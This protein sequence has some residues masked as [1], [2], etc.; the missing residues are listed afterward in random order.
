MGAGR[1]QESSTDPVG[2]RASPRHTGEVMLHDSMSDH[3]LDR[4]PRAT[5]VLDRLGVIQTWNQ[6]ARELFGW[7]DSQVVGRPAAEVLAPPGHEHDLDLMLA[8]IAGGLEWEGDVTVMHREGVTLRV[9]LA[10]RPL[11][12]D[13]GEV[14]GGVSVWEDV[15]QTRLGE[16]QARDVADHLRLALEASELGT[17]RWDKASGV[18][19]WD[20]RM[21]ELFG[22]E[23]GTFTGTFEAWAA[24]LH[25]EEI[26]KSMRTL[27]EA[28][29]TKGAYRLL[30]R[31]VLPDGTTRWLLGTGKV[32]LDSDG[33]VTGTIGC[34]RD[35]TST[36]EHDRERE[37]L[38]AAAITSADE[39]RIHRERLEFLS[40]IND[41]LAEARN[42]EEIM[43]AVTTTA[44]S[45]LG[46]WCSI[47]VLRE[48]DGV[49]PDVEIAH[50]DPE[51]VAFARS[52]GERFPYDPAAPGGLP[53]VIRTGEPEFHPDL[54][55]DVLERVESVL[56]VMEA[57]TRQRE[58][59]HDLVHGSSIAVPLIKRGRILGAMQFV[60]GSSR[61]RYAA[62]DLTLALAVAARIAAALENRRL[63]E[64][65]R[66]IAK[67]L[68]DS[69][70][71]AELPVIAG[72]EVAV[73]YWAAGEGTEVGGDFYDVFAL[74]DDRWAVV[75]GDVCGT[76]PA[77]AALTGLARHSIR[78]S[79]WHG[80]DPVG[81]LTWLNQAISSADTDS[82]CTAAYAQLTR[83]DNTFQLTLASGGHP[84][85]VLATAD[86]TAHE[87]G[88]PGTLLGL[89]DEISCHITTRTLHPGDTLVLYTD[90][91]TDVP[92]PHDLDTAK[93]TRM[94]HLSATGGTTEGTDTADDIA[95]RIRGH[96]EGVLPLQE[97]NDDI[98]LLVL[99]VS[100][101]RH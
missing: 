59:M 47:Y 83:H 100:P 29:A 26:E 23:P 38:I 2:L 30:H 91:V 60:M 22:L 61:R 98:A 95:D 19:E 73:R 20:T 32:T 74:D 54:G 99:R 65:Q 75:I 4:L 89:F 35:V 15:T 72:V 78:M 31:R 34:S 40:R 27:E 17:W 92:P 101:E 16:Q 3:V 10:A 12:D 11:R 71:P 55:E 81:V 94:I 46:D 80:D 48:P 87:L 13:A 62:E 45:R 49:I 21:E 93:L 90:G 77:A 28:I 9:T 68:Q 7:A 6:A 67:T 52:L 56:D 86:G 70:L 14:V 44:V 42:R 82:F 36:V 37:Q 53:H 43:V 79:A 50:I 64:H 51:M 63:A 25:P 57:T 39:E 66:L 58:A 85:P 84:L 1:V 8:R 97:R 76:G 18:T 41:A 96:I 5:V 88:R 33:N 24:L 69:L